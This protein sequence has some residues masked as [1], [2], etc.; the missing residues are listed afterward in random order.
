MAAL[1]QLRTNGTHNIAEIDRIL[2]ERIASL[3]EGLSAVQEEHDE[4]RGLVHRWTAPPYYPA[5]FLTNTNSAEV[6]GALVQIEKEWRVVQVGEGVAP[7]DLTPGDEVFLSHE[8]N[9]LIAK[10]SSPSFLTGEVAS[11]S[12]STGDGRLVLRSRDE[13]MV[14]LP[15]ATLRNAGLKAEMVCA[16]AAPQ[17]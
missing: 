6:Q 5:V 12:R 15:K 14:V 3:R 8:R 16:S 4:L 1:A 2:M 13:E 7:D 9:F 11:Y 10:S 17:D